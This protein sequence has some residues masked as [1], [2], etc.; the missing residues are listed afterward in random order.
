MFV[1]SLENMEKRFFSC[2]VGI[3]DDD[4]DIVFFQRICRIELKM[5]VK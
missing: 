5:L 1:A 3:D 2:C 4:D